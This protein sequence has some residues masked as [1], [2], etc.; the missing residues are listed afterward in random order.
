MQNIKMQSRRIPLFEVVLFT[1][2]ERIC[3]L[4]AFKM[5]WLVGLF[6][7][8]FCVTESSTISHV[9]QDLY[10]IQCMVMHVLSG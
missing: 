8:V 10:Q 3:I 5:F 9:H 4:K 7:G 1:V 6:W 2:R